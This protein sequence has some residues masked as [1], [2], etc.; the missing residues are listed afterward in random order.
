MFAKTI[1]G[2]GLVD[3]ETGIEADRDDARDFCD[4]RLLLAEL[5]FC[6]C[7]NDPAATLVDG[8][9]TCARCERELDPEMM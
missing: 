9:P 8:V 3:L 6:V 1:D 7:E 4:D 5:G 2:N